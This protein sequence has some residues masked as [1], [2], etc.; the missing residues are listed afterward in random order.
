MRWPFTVE[1]EGE[2]VEQIDGAVHYEWLSCLVEAKDYSEPINVEPIAKMRNQLTRRPV[3]T[4]GLI[5]ARSGFTDPAKKLTRRINPL[6]ILLWEPSELVQGLR[7]GTLCRALKTK[8]IRAVEMAEPDYNST[9]G[10]L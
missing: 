5:F 6:N 2:V 9:R 8:Y 1:E 3:G 10:L 7:D 4:L